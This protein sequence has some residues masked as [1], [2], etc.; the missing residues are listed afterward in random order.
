MVGIGSG[1]LV[2]VLSAGIGTAPARADQSSP[3][4]ESLFEQLKNAEDSAQSRRLEGRIWQLW[5][6]VPEGVSQQLIM[7]IES[8]MRTANLDSAL[9]TADQL[10]EIA[11]DYAEG[12]NKRA[13]IK[14]LAGDFDGSVDDIGR[15]LALEPRH[16][17]AISGLGLIFLRR[18]DKQAALEAF[19]KVLEIS[20]ASANA[21]ANAERLRRELETDI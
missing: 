11:P 1:F 16:F 7:D 8:D 14:Y 15:T 6:Q 4:L 13:T 12:W 2:V 19:E 21:G 9:D 20:P 18:G 5:L 10:I 17:G 3:A